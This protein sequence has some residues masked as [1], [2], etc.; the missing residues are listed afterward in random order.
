MIGVSLPKSM[1]R[2]LEGVLELYGKELVS[3]LAKKYGFDE[4]DGLESAGFV[5]VE[6]QEKKKGAVKEATPSIPLPFCGVVEKSWCNGL[7]LNHGL[8]TQCTQKPGENGLCKTCTNQCEKNGTDKPTYGLVSDRM[9][10]YDPE[11]V[12]NWRSPS[13]TLATP[14]TKVMAKVGISRED[15]EKEALKFG[16]TIPEQH[17]IVSVGKAGRPKKSTATSDTE[18]DS[19]KPVPKKRGR[20]KKVKKVVSTNAGDDLIANLLADASKSSQESEDDIVHVPPAEKK[21]KKRSKAKLV[22]PTRD[23]SIPMNKDEV[24][25]EVQAEV[26]EAI[27]AE[28]Q[29]AIQAEVQAEVQEDEEVSVTKFEHN[30]V[31]YLKAT[32]DVLYDALT[33]EEVGT[34]NELEQRV[35]KLPCCE[36]E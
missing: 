13:G 36:F 9:A 27:Q 1:S 25:A 11:N 19:E 14:F 29:E 35:H 5:L 12:R 21:K 20:P 34:W 10:G 28:V 7:R 3:I 30:G 31:K 2:A 4:K 15:A 18:S 6:P 23:V 8:H 22:V 32:D 16:W 26:Q 33:Q 24:Q 17:F